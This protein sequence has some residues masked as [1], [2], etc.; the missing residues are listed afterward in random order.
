MNWKAYTIAAVAALAL[1][2]FPATVN[3][4]SLP[5]W[6]GIYAGV[7]AGHGWSDLDLRSNDGFDSQV[8]FPGAAGIDADGYLLGGH[9]GAQYQVGNVVFGIEADVSKTNGDND[10]F[11]ATQ[12]YINSDGGNG[13]SWSD[14]IAIDRMY[15]LRGRIGY[16]IGRTMIYGT[17]GVAWADAE[18]THR[19]A[20][21]PNA[22]HAVVRDSRTFNGY[23]VG[24]GIEYAPSSNVSIRLEYLYTDMGRETFAFD[25]SNTNPPQPDLVSADLDMHV[26]RVGLTFLLG[27]GG[28]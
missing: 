13:T 18:A 24:G 10:A 25:V 6:T 23:V 22:P 16:A 12:D 20:D 7:H 2:A 14:S 17:G 15:S 26:A 19:V 11:F 9:A 5:N 28:E 8:L 27:P 4:Q 1:L 21:G 3:A